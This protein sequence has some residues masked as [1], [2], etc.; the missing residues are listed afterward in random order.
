MSLEV[1]LVKKDFKNFRYFSN[2][3][4]IIVQIFQQ[5]FFIILLFLA[6]SALQLVYVNGNIILACELFKECLNLILSKNVHLKF[7]C[8]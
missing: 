1:D 2:Y 6:Y 5:T 4:I 7:S 8:T 3:E